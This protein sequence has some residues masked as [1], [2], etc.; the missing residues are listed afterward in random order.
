VITHR[1]PLEEFDQGFKLMTTGPRDTG[2]VILF[3]NGM[4]G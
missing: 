2:K 3:P 4:P 1:L